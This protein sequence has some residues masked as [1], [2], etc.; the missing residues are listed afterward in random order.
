MGGTKRKRFCKGLSTGCSRP[1]GETG[2]ITGG[3]KKCGKKTGK[4]GLERELCSSSSC[5]IPGKG[6]WVGRGFKR[7]K[8]RKGGGGWLFVNVS[9]F[10][11]LSK[12]SQKTKTMG[13]GKIDS[14]EE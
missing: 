2:D 12:G 3:A 1:R 5:S 8:I 10:T 7:E 14:E 11:H 13:G 9:K 4:G 6:P